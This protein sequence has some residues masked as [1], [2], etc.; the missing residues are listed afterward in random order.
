MNSKTNEIII[1]TKK[2]LFGANIGR[3]VS[4][5]KGDGLDFREIREYNYGD[6]VKKINW[7][8]TAKSG[9]NKLFVNEFN[10]ERELNIVFLFMISGNI[11]FGSSR[12]KQETMAEALSMLSFAALLEDNKVTTIFFSDKLEQFFKPTKNINSPYLTV[13]YAINLNPIGKRADYKS[14]FEYLN[15]TIKQRSLI[16]II[17]DFYEDIDISML[18]KHEVYCVVVRDSFEENPNFDSEVELQD[19]V[20]E[21]IAKVDKSLIDDYKK[22]IKMHDNRLFEEFDNYNIRFTKLFTNEDIYFKLLN[23][24][25]V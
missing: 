3:N 2:R 17:G 20:T 18:L 19:L 8:V 24:C 6:D 15:N 9:G 7:K 25:A 16:F 1:K 22:A 12:S 11:Y 13:D 14:A 4:A 10:Q 23:L 5:F 21:E